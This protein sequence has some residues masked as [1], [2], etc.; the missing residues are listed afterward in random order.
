MLPDGV[1]I[2][3]TL[4]PGGNVAVDELFE[5]LP[6]FETSCTFPTPGTRVATTPVTFVFELSGGGTTMPSGLPV[7]NVVAVV[8]TRQGKQV[9]VELDGARTVELTTAGV[10]ADGSGTCGTNLLIHWLTG[11]A[12][13]PAES[14]VI[15]VRRVP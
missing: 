8:A 11:A 13:V 1:Q 9:R 10:N 6:F 14:Q 3:T 12:T 15:T 2:S 7:A 5:S 4:S